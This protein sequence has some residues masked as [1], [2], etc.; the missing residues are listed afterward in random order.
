MVFQDKLWILGGNGSGTSGQVLYSS[1]GE[2]WSTATHTDY[3]GT[4]GSSVVAFLGRLWIIGGDA[5]ALTM[6]W[7]SSD[8]A[9]WRQETTDAPDISFCAAAV[10]DGKI[11]L[12][13]G[14]DPIAG[15]RRNDVWSSND[16]IHWEKIAVTPPYGAI[17]QAT[18][19]DYGGFLWL[20]GGSY[21]GN[22]N[23]VAP[24]HP[25]WFSKDG[26]K[27]QAM[28]PSPSILATGVDAPYS[29]FGAAVG[30]F[31]SGLWSIFG[32]NLGAILPPIPDR[33]GGPAESP[34]KS[35]F[36]LGVALC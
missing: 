14:G 3:P 2:N 33:F 23:W 24:P 9:T 28:D 15:G 20:L 21:P 13:G 26:V 1:D 16:G 19:V 7:S 29:V 30:V 34:A 12:V 22:G 18:A 8:G 10:H 35:R 17:A 27:W 4:A 32:Q 11:Y 5:D 25:I 6:V 31:Q 36:S